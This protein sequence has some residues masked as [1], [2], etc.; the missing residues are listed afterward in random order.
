M[1]IFDNQI[2]VY[3]I[4][5]NKTYKSKRRYSSVRDLIK[6]KLGK[7]I[8]INELALKSPA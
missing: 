5:L 6:E 1:N 2:T 3:L 8:Y 4:I 7:D